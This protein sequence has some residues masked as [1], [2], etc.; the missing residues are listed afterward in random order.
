MSPRM[1]LLSLMLV[2]AVP[3]PLWPQSLPGFQKTGT[4]DEQVKWLQQI[5]VDGRSLKVSDVLNEARLSPLLSN[6]GPIDAVAVRQ[7]AAWEK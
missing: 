3:S 2:L 7:T 4:F 5:I 6:E 1:I